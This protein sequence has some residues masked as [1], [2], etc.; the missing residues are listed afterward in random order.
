M[1]RNASEV[2]VAQIRRAIRGIWNRNGGYL[3]RP[4]RLLAL[5]AG[6]MKLSAESELISITRAYY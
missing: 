5:G 6:C 2:F 4:C 3:I 1:E